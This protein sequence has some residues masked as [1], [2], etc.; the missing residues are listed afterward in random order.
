MSIFGENLKNLRLAAGLRQEDLVKQLDGVVARSTLASVES[1][2]ERPSPR[3]WSALERALPEWAAQLQPEYRVARGESDAA[4]NGDLRWA[5]PAGP[6]T[7]DGARYVYTW[8]DHRAPEE[9]IEVRQVR[10]LQDGADAYVLKLDTD[11]IDS[12]LDAEALWGGRTDQSLVRHEDGRT[13]VMHRFVLD[14]P[15]RRGE[16][17][18]FALRSWI[19]KECDPPSVVTLTYTIPIREAALHLN[20]L[21]PRPSSVW[22]FGPLADDALA[23]DPDVAARGRV[24]ENGRQASAYFRKPSLNTHYGMAWEW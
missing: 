20:F 12:E 4:P 22:R 13:L 17:T 3:L 6:F 23:R 24:P 18:S 7:L 1:G 8:R 21:G 5:N 9:I 16:T 10:A 19:T 14:R 15:L 11:G 2:R